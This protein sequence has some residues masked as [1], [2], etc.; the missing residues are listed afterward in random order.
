MAL[1]INTQVNSLLAQRALSRNHND[2]E[3][4]LDR[5]ASLQR[6]NSAADDVSSLFISQRQT[7]DIRGINQA[8]KNAS[9][10]ISLS[11]TADGNLRQVS[12]NLQRVRELAVQASNATVENREVLQIEV[13]QLTQEISRTLQNSSFNGQSLFS[14]DSELKFAVGEDG[15]ES[16]QVSIPLNSLNGLNSFDADNNAKLTID[17]SSED[18]ARNAISQIDDDLDSVV[19]ERSSFGAFQKRFEAAIESLQD[20]EFNLESARSRIL[21]ADVAKES[22]ALISSKI[23]EESSLLTLVQGNTTAETAL[24]LLT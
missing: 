14:S 13:D 7:S 5:L 6:V 10:G 4:S 19:E 20:R 11:Q 23:R 16:N 21:D 1:T 2:I 24:T 15:G 22:A 9:D 12:S 18:A 8:V 3:R 17:I